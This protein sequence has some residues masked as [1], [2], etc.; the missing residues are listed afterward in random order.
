MWRLVRR[1]WAALAAIGLIVAVSYLGI[2]SGFFQ[3]DEWLAFGRHILLSDMGARELLVS[4]FTPYSAHYTPLTF[5]SIN[6][7]FSLFSLNYLGYAAVS[8]GLHIITVILVFYLA[9]LLFKNDF[10][11][12]A[13]ATLFSISAAGYQ[14][15]TWVV[16]DIATHGATIFGLLSLIFILKFVSFPKISWLYLSIILLLISLLFKEITIGLFVI[17]PLIFYLFVRKDL[18]SKARLPLIFFGVFISYFAFRVILFV[19]SPV[20]LTSSEGTN[21]DYLFSNAVAYPV[22]T[23]VQTVVPPGQILQLSDW[24]TSS[25]PEDIRGEKGTT[26]FDI[27]A[28]G[29]VLPVMELLLF[30]LISSGL[31]VLLKSSI[32]SNFKKTLVFS[33]L[34]IIINSL[35]YVVSPQ[36]TGTVSIIDSRNLYFPLIGTSILIVAVLAKIT[37]SNLKKAFLLLLPILFLNIF[38]LKQEINVLVERGTERRRILSEIK[39]EYPKLP[40][41]VVFYTESDVIPYGLPPGERILPFQSGFG[42]T[43]LVWYYQTE[44]FPKELYENRF[45]WEITEEGYKEVGQRGFGYFRD[46][47]SLVKNVSENK[48]DPASILAFSYNSKDKKITDITGQTRGEILGLNASKFEVDLSNVSVNFSHNG[49][50]GF[51]ALDGKRNTYWSSETPYAAKPQYFEMD[52]KREIEIAQI[53]LDSFD[54][55]DQNEVGYAVSLSENGKDWEEI[56]RTI[57]RTPRQDGIIDIYLSKSKTRFLRVDQIGEHE[58]AP[59]VIHELQVYEATN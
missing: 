27:F 19:S 8:I 24:F 11:A 3:Q 59:W 54:N 37:E 14:A 1:D 58:Y 57:R 17:I 2:F 9:R 18:K 53:R 48:I 40:G 34:F 12:F 43:L 39:N 38:W 44:K 30:L 15:T 21:K 29:R 36:R 33:F 41:K 22:K 56:F 42:Q 10:F 23:V 13:T 31:F 6:L 16:A 4:I 20:N 35:V 7:L 45:L 28:Q 50:H 55:K 52:F 25:L 51:L 26:A 5:L 32:D 47:D 49:P 46:F